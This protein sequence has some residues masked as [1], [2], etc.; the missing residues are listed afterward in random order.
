MIRSS[1]SI[2]LNFLEA[3]AAESIRDFR[4][5]VMIYLKEN[6]ETQVALE[7]AIT[8]QGKATSRLFD[9]SDE[10]ISTF[11]VMAKN[12]QSK[13]TSN[14]NSDSNSYS[15]Q[16][17]SKSGSRLYLLDFTGSEPEPE[18]RKCHN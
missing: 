11:V 4:H 12:V 15:I 2:V 14:S 17:A 1:M 13:M 5:K 10:I 8:V 18:S 3:R 9:E 6:R 7:I 16:H